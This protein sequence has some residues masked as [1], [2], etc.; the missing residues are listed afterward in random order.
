MTVSGTDTQDTGA[1]DKVVPVT[2]IEDLMTLFHTYGDT[3]YGEDV[4][5]TQHMIQCALLAEEQGES[6]EIIVAA[7]LHDVGHF[8]GAQADTGTPDEDFHHE[9]LGARLLNKL[10]PNSVTT[11]IQLHVAAK[12]YLCAKSEDYLNSLSPA[13]RHSLEIQGGPMSTGQCEKFERSDSFQAAITLRNLD[14]NGKQV[15]LDLPT[16]GYFRNYLEQVALQP[17]PTQSM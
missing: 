17:R 8:C 6:A 12:R 13:S 5:Q 15:G 9:V 2:S 10:F 4:S 14:D 1:L 11:P 16:L 3:H 7:L